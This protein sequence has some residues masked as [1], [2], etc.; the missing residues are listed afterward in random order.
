MT[1]LVQNR[2]AWIDGPGKAIRIGAH[3]LRKLKPGEILIKNRAVAINPFDCLQQATGEFI[4]SWPCIL[5]HDLAGDI[6]SVGEGVTAFAPG[7][8]VLAQAVQQGPEN[9]AFQEHTIVGENVACRIPDDLVYESACV[10]PLALSTAAA[11]LYQKGYLEL[12]LP[13]NPPAVNLGKTLLVWGGS[14]S[15]GSAAIQ[16][17]VASGIEVV[18][19]ASPRNFEHCRRLGARE[20]MDYNS[21][22]I[23]EDIVTTLKKTGQF[24]GAFAGKKIGSSKI[25]AG[26]NDQ[27]LSA[28]RVRSSRLLHRS[29]RSSAEA[30]SLRRR[31]LRATFHRVSVQRW[32]SR[33]LFQ[34]KTNTAS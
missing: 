8:R 29:W 9:T 30:L 5:G 32:V 22:T 6:V 11:G 14:S 31:R 10:V 33:I 28:N 20:V 34:S 23:I 1:S 21:S 19:T 17:A 13:T 12:P 15:V 16:L 3:D 27:Q 24:V 26:S 18:T 7:H 4:E 2:A 25:D